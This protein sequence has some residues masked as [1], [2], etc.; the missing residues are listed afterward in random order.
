MQETYRDYKLH[1]EQ[2]YD[3]SYAAFTD[4]Y[5]GAIDAGRQLTGHGSTPEE[6]ITELKL[7]ITEH[8]AELAR[9]NQPEW[10]RKLKIHY[11]VEAQCNDCGEDIEEA[12][13]TNEAGQ[14]VHITTVTNGYY[15]NDGSVACEA[16][17]EGNN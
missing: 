17:H 2:Q 12:H 11:E 10:Y 1:T 14:P 7:E 4:D 5:D 16:C 3:C 6:A 15:Y 9:K 8:L 13:Y